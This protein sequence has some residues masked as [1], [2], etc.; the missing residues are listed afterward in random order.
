MLSADTPRGSGTRHKLLTLVT[1]DF[2]ISRGSPLPLGTTIV[3]DGINFA[4]FSKHATEVTLVVYSPDEASSIVE[5]PLD[6]RINRTGEVWHVYIRGLH[7]GIHYGYRINGP[8]DHHLHR[9][10]P[11]RVLLDPY[12]KAISG[13]CEWGQPE[14]EVYRHRRCIIV[15]EDFDWGT[16]QPLN[17]PL[18][19][20]VIYE[21][22]VRGFTQHASSAVTH[23]GTFAGLIEKIPYLKSLGVTA[24][25]LLPVNEFEELESDRVNPFTGERLL[26]YWGYQPISFFAPNA[27]YASAC[28]GAQV[29]EF[30]RLVKSFHD[31]GIE[32]I[33]DVVFNHTAEGD[34]RGPTLSFRG[35]DNS[36]YYMLD[37]E[38]GTYR[39]YSGCGNTLN[40]NHPLV[41]EM[42]RDCLRYWV[43]EMHV[44]G[45]RFDL[46]SILGRGQDGSVL[47]N[48]PLL[49]R[50]AHDPVLA[51]TKLIAE[52]W[53]AAGL[54]QVG[55]FPAWGRWAE[56][57]GKFRDDIR[58][59]VKGEAGM[60]PALAARLLGSPDL[61]QTSNREPY[62]SINFVTCHDGF[63]LL[64][65]VS[66]NQKHNEVNGE[67]NRDGA[68]QNLS[69]NCGQE[70]LTP[71]ASINRLRRQ[72]RKNFATLLLASHGVPMILAGDELGRTQR[73]NNNAYCQ[74][75]E[76]SWLD[77]TWSRDAREMYRFFRLL[78]AFR[79]THQLLRRDSFSSNEHNGGP[80]I[81]WHG[82][83]LHQPDWSPESRSLAMHLHSP[84]FEGGPLE[85]IYLIA[86]AHWEPAKF[87]LP[88]IPGYTWT[89]VVDTALPCPEDIADE[90]REAPLLDPVSYTVAGRATILLLA[91]PIA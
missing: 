40:C 59:F 71:Q 53:D 42:I 51:H 32:V 63:T 28:H 22:H 44:D 69:W 38:T 66:Y 83:S 25:E 18:S 36:I 2:A 21:L 1:P 20:S 61:Y 4:I 26:N 37:R 81:A 8:R 65:L 73:G 79:R 74:D 76:V 46:A 85:H 14:A 17:I 41:R 90:G 43:T 86:N 72:Q 91:K 10:D 27:A 67:E 68:D 12:A 77:W 23:P 3:R 33:L 31:A 54:Y 15:D 52:A 29:T 19:D 13:G 64:D 45:F 16:D 30:K 58:R 24:V 55:T 78:I 89:R 6:P 48:P 87:D 62:H 56:W 49:E 7:P 88:Q 9:F 70:G 50:L 34:D 5:F 47:S 11:G 57:N 82:H 35:I 39:N 80:H 75:N 84:G 60:V